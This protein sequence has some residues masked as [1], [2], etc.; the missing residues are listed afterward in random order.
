M[1]SE[2]QQKIIAFLQEHKT[3]SGRQLA[4]ILGRDSRSA[5]NIL[6]T[7]YAEK[8]LTIAVLESAVNSSWLQTGKIIFVI[9]KKSH[10]VNL[11]HLPLQRFAVKTGRAIRFI[12]FSGV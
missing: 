12:K 6:S 7:C 4:E 8:L 10:G 2:N 5:W 9:L 3:A 1:N 11:R